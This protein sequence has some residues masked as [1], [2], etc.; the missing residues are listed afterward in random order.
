M[1]DIQYKNTYIILGQSA[2]HE[3]G[4]PAAQRRQRVGQAENRTREV[5]CNVQTVTQV[6]GSDGAVQEQLH[7]EDDH[8]PG[9][10]V[11]EEDLH[12]HQDAGQ[13]HCECGEDLARLCGGQALGASEVVGKRGRNDGHRVLAQVG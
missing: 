12:A 13:H 11:A 7:R 4:Q 8:R 3:G 5:R 2:H 9:A 10:I 6:A 1:G